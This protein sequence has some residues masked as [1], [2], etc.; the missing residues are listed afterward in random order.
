MAGRWEAEL[1]VWSGAFHSF[2]E[3]VP[4][5]VVTRTAKQT[6]ADR[7]RRL[8]ERSGLPCGTAEKTR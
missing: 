7:L 4:D 6:R 3:W 2:D 8:L 1:H 5:A